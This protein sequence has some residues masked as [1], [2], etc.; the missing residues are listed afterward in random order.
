[1]QFP[2]GIQVVSNNLLGHSVG[3]DRVLAMCLGDGQVLWVYDPVNCPARRGKDHLL[4]TC[5]AGTFNHVECS[6]DVHPRIKGWVENRDTNIDLCR[7]VKHHVGRIP[8][9]Q[10][11]NRWIADINLVE[12]KIMI[13]IGTRIGQVSEFAR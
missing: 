10:V 5:S 8:L 2:K 9:D 1:M 3:S 12:R 7:K 6:Q 4:G 11:G 13:P